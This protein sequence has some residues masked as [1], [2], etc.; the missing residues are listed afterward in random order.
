MQTFTI[1]GKN[2]NHFELREAD[3]VVR[4]ALG[5]VGSAEFSARRRS[6][7]A[8]RAAMQEALPRLKAALAVQ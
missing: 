6:I 1:M 2:I 3:L 8:G 7:E 4:P 5:N